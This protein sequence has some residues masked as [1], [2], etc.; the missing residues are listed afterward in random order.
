M[1][2]VHIWLIFVFVVVVFRGVWWCC[3]LVCDIMPVLV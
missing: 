1:E 2:I 3:R